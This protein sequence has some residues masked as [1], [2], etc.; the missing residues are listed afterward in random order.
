MD[1]IEAK[2]TWGRWVKMIL[3]CL[4][5]VI[6]APLLLMIG[7]RRLRSIPVDDP[8]NR[9]LKIALIYGFVLVMLGFGF[10]IWTFMPKDAEKVE[11]VAWLPDV[12]T[13]VSYY[14]FPFHCEIYEFDISETHFRTIY[15]QEK[16]E[17]IKEPVTIRRYTA[18]MDGVPE[19]GRT[20]TVKNGLC[21]FGK[22]DY[23]TGVYSKEIVFDRES[24]RAYFCSEREE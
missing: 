8:N 2:T 17:E 14:R 16:L 24:G 19:D 11:K 7:Y 21:C 10:L 15:A 5:G 4:L 13:N 3:L 22:E 23:V 12:A 1:I 6:F 18:R 20:V 9:A